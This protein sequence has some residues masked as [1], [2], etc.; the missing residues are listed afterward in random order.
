L[1]VEQVG[2]AYSIGRRC[3]REDEVRSDREKQAIGSV[4][5]AFRVRRG[6]IQGGQDGMKTDRVVIQVFLRHLVSVMSDRCVV[7]ML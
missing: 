1:A 2:M 7:Y 3:R 4:R 6:W 5:S